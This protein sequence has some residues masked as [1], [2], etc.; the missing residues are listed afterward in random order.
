[1]A[2]FQRIFQTAAVTLA[3]CCA[4]LLSSQ[5]LAAEPRIISTDAGATNLI[6][7]LGYGHQLIAVDVTSQLP[8][9]YSKL[10]RLGY[11]RNLSAEGLLSLAP[12]LVVGSEHMGPASAVTALQKSGI[13]LLQLPA[14]HTPAILARNIERLGAVLDD[15]PATQGLLA[16]LAQKQ[17]QLAQQA[18]PAMTM[19]FLL[20]IGGEKLRMAGHGTSGEAFIKLLGGD[21]LADFQNYQSVSDESLLAL[22]P[23]LIVI[24]SNNSDQPHNSPLSD[25]VIAATPAGINGHIHTVDGNTL[26][27][28]LS[29]AA[30]DQAA[31]ISSR[32]GADNDSVATH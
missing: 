16:E 26:V 2:L 15:K 8:A 7:A 23:Q 14:A 10:A 22:Q 11:H 24:A 31:A 21:N 29:L 4:P 25:A 9:A 30:I 13:P 5:A 19:V 17:T 27:A 18:A 20:D 12:S 6:V 32:L 1:M 3:C 28:G